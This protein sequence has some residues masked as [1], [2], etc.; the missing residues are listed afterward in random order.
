MATRG[1]RVGALHS[2]CADPSPKEREDIPPGRQA[3]SFDRDRRISR[4][5]RKRSRM[6]QTPN[7]T[8]PYILAAQS[9]KHVTH[10]EAIRA[11]DALVQMAVVDRDLA[12]PP[13]SPANGDR[14]IVAAGASGAWA[15]QSGKI[16]AFQDA[17]WTIYAPRAGWLAWIADESLLVVWSGTSWAAAGGGGGSVNP[18]PLVGVN[19]TADTTNRLS[20]AS[21]STLLNHAGSGHQLKINKSAAADTASLLYQTAFSGRAELGLTGDDNLHVKVSADGTTWREAIVVDRSTGAV[22]LP[23]TTPAAGG[24][25]QNVLVNGDF[26][27]NQRVF[28]GGSLSAG[29]YGFDRWKADAGG[30]S[31]TVSSFTVTLTSGTIVQ[32]IEP[33]LWG[34]ASFASVPMTVSIDSPAAD[35][36]VT[37]GSLTGTITAGSGRRS[38]TLTVGAGETGNL[39]FKLAKATAGSVSFA[40]VKLEVGSAATPWQARPSVEE[41]RLCQR[42]F[43]KSYPYAVAPGGAIFAGSTY[44]VATAGDVTVGFNFP[45]PMRAGPTFTTYAPNSGT[46]GKIADA[47]AAATELT[48]TAISPQPTG[49][50]YWHAPG[51]TVGKSYFAQWTADAEL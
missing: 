51:M 16:A 8:L 47:G 2:P 9:Q 31:I 48:A 11:L 18:T 26:Q 7:L 35:M 32:V 21:P 13:T 29:V 27:L 38:V 23:N 4:T 39:T 33:A 46:V 14:Y 12:V 22:T 42:Y 45:S 49:L 17:A 3:P 15:G 10:N 36:T 19:A 28:A 6:D 37:L 34:L 1:P 30:A 50:A 25:L 5:Q 43:Q 41:I 40:R 44:V 20:V 24:S